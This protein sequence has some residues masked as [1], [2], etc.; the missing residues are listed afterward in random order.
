MARPRSDIEPRILDAARRRFRQSGVEGS[1]LRAIA[2]DAG[3]SIGMIYYYYPTKDEL[4]FAVVEATYA[5]MMA[6]LERVLA[7][8]IPVAERLAHLF[9]RLAA[10]SDEE[11]EILRLVVL[12]GLMSTQRFERLVARFMRGHIAL[13]LKTVLDGLAD[14]TLDRRRHPVVLL[15]SMFALAGPPQL[16]RRV[17]GD[18]L[19]VPGAPSGGVL[20]RELVDILLHGV[21]AKTA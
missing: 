8:E 5:T 21:A 11:I 4:F 18:R 12:E 6:D 17:V 2:R 1:S 14:G 7:P 9:E 13:G 15:L 20:A 10:L 19:P 3:T 16:L